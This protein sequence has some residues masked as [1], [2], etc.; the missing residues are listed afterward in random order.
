[1]TQVKEQ[2]VKGSDVTQ[3]GQHKMNG[4]RAGNRNTRQVKEAT[5][6]GML[7]EDGE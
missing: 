2:G 1:M 3:T 5:R 4:G 7:I 6:Y